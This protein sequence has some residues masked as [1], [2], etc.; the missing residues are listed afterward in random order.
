M[1]KSASLKKAV[2]YARYATER[3]K[4]GKFDEQYKQCIKHI[5][6]SGYELAGVYTDERATGLHT[7]HPA[8][9]ELRAD[10]SAGKFDIVVV[11]DHSRISRDAAAAR[12]FLDEMQ[13]HSVTVE[14]VEGL[15]GVSALC[16]LKR[17]K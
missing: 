11:F 7:D 14:S 3:A 13:R 16:Q 9:N 8:L 6:A 17:I 4:D 1:K 12:D 2:I 5:E 15:K 10:A